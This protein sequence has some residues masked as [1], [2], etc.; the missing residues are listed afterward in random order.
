[1]SKL[2]IR[3]KINDASGKRTGV[4]GRVHADDESDLRGILARGGFLEIEDEDGNPYEWVNIN[5]II[6]IRILTEETTDQVY[7]A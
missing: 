4:T 5:H 3:A 6:T 7:Y 1:M 2:Q